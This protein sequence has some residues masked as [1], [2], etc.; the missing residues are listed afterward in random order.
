[1]VAAA[2]ALSQPA[3]A[4]WSACG[5]ADAPS[6]YSSASCQSVCTESGSTVTCELDTICSVYGANAWIIHASTSTHDLSAFGAC[7][8]ATKFCCVYDEGT[9]N[10]DTV[11]LNGL[12]F[13]GANDTLSFN[14]PE[15]GYLEPWDGDDIEGI[16]RANQGADYLYGSPYDGADYHETL[17]GQRGADEL[18]GNNG[19]DTLD[20][21]DEDDTLWGG[22]GTDHLKGGKGADHL[23]GEVG[24]DT[25]WGGDGNDTLEGGA[26]ND[27]LCDS[28]GWTVCA[29]SG[30]GGNL[31][32]GNQG[33]DKLWF[34]EIEGA[35][36][37]G[38]LPDPASDGGQDTDTC[39]DTDNF[40]QDDLPICENFTSSEPAKC[41]GQL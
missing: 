6:E 7:D 35:S 18:F 27:T 34:D 21:G 32:L 17:F 19:N 11:E 26:N 3:F 31:L 39:G 23:Y 4:G 9:T 1:M 33:Q 8:T 38:V 2:S 10:I 22:Y 37:G 5:P 12:D 28:S 29:T 41:E 25:L 24:N 36:C 30:T 13:T 40:D 16:I 20:G 14:L 15:L